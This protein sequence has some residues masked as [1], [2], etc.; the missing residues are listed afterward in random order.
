MEI[1]YF[2]IILLLIIG[3]FTAGLK[4]S[5]YYHRQANEWQRYALQKQYARLMTKSDADDPCQPYVAPPT[6]QRHPIPDKF[7]EHLRKNGAATMQL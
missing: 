2:S 1:L 4:L 7:V 6:S 5:N 3:A